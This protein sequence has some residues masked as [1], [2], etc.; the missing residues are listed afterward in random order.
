MSNLKISIQEQLNFNSLVSIY[1]GYQEKSYSFVCDSAYVQ[2][3][4]SCLEAPYIY[5]TFSF[6]N[7]EE[8]IEIKIMKN[9][10]EFVYQLFYV[11]PHTYEGLQGMVSMF[12][13]ENKIIVDQK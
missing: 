4:V 2:N 13:Q 5:K 10:E 7:E 9:E 11:F 3:L 6:Q 1:D 8:V 12:D